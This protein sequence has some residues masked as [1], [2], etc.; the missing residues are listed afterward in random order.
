VTP[1]LSLFVSNIQPVA[2]APTG[3]NVSKLIYN[4]HE[5]AKYGCED[6]M[7]VVSGAIPPQD[8]DAL[9]QAGASAIFP[10]GTVIADAA[11]NLIDDVN[12]RLG[13]G[14]KQAAA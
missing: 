14:L 5:L 4:R 12:R 8:F 13:Y 7:I 1:L 6:I 10:P 3:V 2:L 9:H 11:V